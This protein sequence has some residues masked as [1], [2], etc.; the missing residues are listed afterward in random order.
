MRRSFIPF[1]KLYK[2]WALYSLAL[3]VFTSVSFPE[4]STA[5]VFHDFS[6]LRDTTISCRNIDETM[7]SFGFAGGMNSCQYGHIDLNGDGIKDLVVF[8]RH[9]NRLMP[10]IRKSNGIDGYVYSPGYAK[11]F[12]KMENWMQLIDYNGDGREDI[13]TYTTGGIK[14]YRNSSSGVPKFVQVSHPY[15][16]SLQGPSYT[17]ILVTYAD[18][19]AISDIDGDGDLDILTF[20]GLGSF[21]EFHKNMSMEKYDNADSLD[22][23]RTETCW[24]RF[25]EGEDS[26][27]ITLDTCM[28]VKPEEY[29]HSDTERDGDPKHTGSTLL[30]IDLDGDH[31]KDLVLG[32]VDYPALKALW[33]GGDTSYALITSVDQAFPVGSQPVNLVSFPASCLIDVN[34]DGLD[35]LLISPFDPSLI[36]SESSHSSWLYLNSGTVSSPVFNLSKKNYLQNEMLDFGSGAYPVAADVDGDGLTDLLVGN[37]GYLDSSY[38]ETGHILR[39]IYKSQ[40][41]YVRNSGTAGAPSFRLITDDFA[42]LSEYKILSAYPSSADLD[43]DGDADLLVGN[44]D[45]S[46]IFF[47]NLAGPGNYPVYAPPVF[48]YQS[49][50]VGDYSAP[51]LIDLDQDGLVDLVSGKR[52]GKISYYRNTGSVSNPVFTFIT[53]FLGNVDVSDPQLSYYGYSTPCFFKSTDSRWRLFVGSESRNVIYY[54][55]ISDNLGG[56]FSQDEAPVQNIREGIRTGVAV[57]NADADSYPDM[58]IGNYAGG[59]AFYRGI[60]P[61]PIGIEEHIPI[62]ECQVSLYPNPAS[63][64]LYINIDL[65]E[66]SGKAKISIFRIDGSIC[67]A[68]CNIPIAD[69]LSMLVNEF[70]NGIYICKISLIAENGTISDVV[71]RRLVIAR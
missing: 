66:Y 61:Q 15:L 28:N 19:P 5:Q 49:L 44:A 38:Y 35:D 69:K 37:Y 39:C 59:L 17:N 51:Q 14:V 41:A 25:A 71:Y 46:F 31:D 68:S 30:A 20:W 57:F 60:A 42:N 67:Y 32:D 4:F 23:L 3:L 33:N 64:R 24:G 34:N 7:L 52:D 45:G 29:L 70:A 12:P 65:P 63:D 50:D 11:Y 9:G 27:Q 16:R 56:A 43:G 10:F 22:F 1:S 18:Y 58:V 48:H 21:V 8:D 55:D 26:D 6:F 13:F 54:K 2:I 47:E 62:A 36:R 40:L 53:D